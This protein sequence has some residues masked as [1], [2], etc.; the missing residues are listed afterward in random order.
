MKRGIKIV[1]RIGVVAIWVSALFMAFSV[2][3]ARNGENDVIT[4]GF[5]AFIG[6]VGLGVHYLWRWVLLQNNKRL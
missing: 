1:Y 4:F 3:V 6:L 2:F 5:L